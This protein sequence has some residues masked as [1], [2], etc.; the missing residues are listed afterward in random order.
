MD[1]QH[2]EN[3]IPRNPGRRRPKRL[4]AAAR[5]EIDDMNSH[6]EVPASKAIRWPHSL[7]VGR[8]LK[9]NHLMAPETL[10]DALYSIFRDSSGN[11]LDRASCYFPR[12]S[13]H[14][15]GRRKIAPRIGVCYSAVWK[16]PSRAA[17]L[18]ISSDGVPDTDTVEQFG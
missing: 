14:L 18:Q 13:I 16:A 7:C 8:V 9:T 12:L 5:T 2:S 4:A 15:K 3:R 6:G 1:T 11:W 10:P 17:T